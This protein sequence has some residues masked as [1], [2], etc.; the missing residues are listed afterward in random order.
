MVKRLPAIAL[1]LLLIGLLLSP[2]QTGEFVKS[3][4]TA[5]WNAVATA[6]SSF[7]QK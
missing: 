3:S 5:G 2:A 4:V 1:G 6:A 7:S